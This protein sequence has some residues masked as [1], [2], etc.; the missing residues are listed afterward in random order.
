VWRA[1]LYTQTRSVDRV[2]Y[3]LD[4]HADLLLLGCALAVWFNLHGEPTTPHARRVW[5]M[6]AGLGG[7]VLA[8]S[9]CLLEYGDAVM[10]HGL[11]SVVALAAVAIVGQAVVGFPRTIALILQNPFMLWIGRTSFGMYLWHYLF[12]YAIGK[13]GL[14]RHL[15]LNRATTAMIMLGLVWAGTLAAASLSYYL[16]EKR[17]L[18]MKPTRHRPTFERI[19]K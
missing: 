16:V 19:T 3:G 7:I 14:L 8:I 11:Y 15:G 18:A 5:G 12:I 2:Y 10:F 13:S 17:F 1:F 4:T 9:L 6:A